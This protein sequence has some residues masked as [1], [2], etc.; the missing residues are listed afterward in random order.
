MLLGMY[1][2]LDGL[3]LHELLALLFLDC[4]LQ[5]WWLDG[6]Y[7]AVMAGGGIG[8][9]LGTQSSD[10][11]AVMK[12][13][14]LKIH[15]PPAHPYPR[16]SGGDCGAGIPGQKPWKKGAPPPARDIFAAL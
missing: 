14:R 15:T 3:P 8:L 1:C 2:Q 10:A 7:A 9:I 11:L 6:R 12:G 4:I 13:L 16:F 5:C